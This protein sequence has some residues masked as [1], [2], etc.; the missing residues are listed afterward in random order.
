MFLRRWLL[1][2]FF[3]VF[4]VAYW[5]VFFTAGHTNLITTWHVVTPFWDELWS[6]TGIGVVN[7]PMQ[8]ALV[9]F[10]AVSV[11]LI[12]ATGLFLLGAFLVLAALFI[13][14]AIVYYAF[15]LHPIVG[16]FAVFWVLGMWTLLLSPFMDGPSDGGSGRSNRLPR[17]YARV[18]TAAG[19]SSVEKSRPDWPVRPGFK[20]TPDAVIEQSFLLGDTKAAEIRESF[21]TGQHN[22]YKGYFGQEKIGSVERNIF[23]DPTR[24]VDREGNTV[25]TIKTTL[26][27]DKIIVDEEG[28][29]IG[30]YHD[31]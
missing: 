3:P 14:I 11:V 21:F 25:G 4:I 22:I 10:A 15:K 27:G 23:G 19:E 5:I 30:E 31:E 28:N 18:A 20:V 12:A 17:T 6:P 8:V 29:T 2:L 26:F 7:F 24:I 1:W 16:V 13:G 9:L